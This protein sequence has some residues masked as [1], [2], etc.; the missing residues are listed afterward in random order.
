V[1]HLQPIL[2]ALDDK[3]LSL[4]TPADNDWDFVRSTGR[5]RLVNPLVDRY[6]LAPFD[7]DHELSKSDVTAAVSSLPEFT[8]DHPADLLLD[9]V[10][11]LTL[12][13]STSL[14]L[15]LSHITT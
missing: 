10:A 7:L 1:C 9:P 2:K 8:L 5:N 15:S 11:D 3:K 12:S 14:S 13:L 4:V 6:R